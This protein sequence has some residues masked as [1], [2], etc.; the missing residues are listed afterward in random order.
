M[1]ILVQINSVFARLRLTLA[2]P[3]VGSYITLQRWSKYDHAQPINNGLGPSL[4]YISL[5]CV[6]RLVV[7]VLPIV[8]NYHGHRHYKQTVTFK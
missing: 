4:L 1:R 2:S 7:S 8:M 6:S 5:T 3:E